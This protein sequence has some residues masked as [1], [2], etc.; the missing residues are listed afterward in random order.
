MTKAMKASTTEVLELTVRMIVMVERM[1]AKASRTTIV[2]K[3]E[4]S[5]GG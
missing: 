4:N 5:G 3:L 1:T 2:I